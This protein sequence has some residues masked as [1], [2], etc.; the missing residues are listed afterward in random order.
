M[1]AQLPVLSLLLLLA[2]HLTSMTLFHF[3]F[4]DLEAGFRYFLDF[5]HEASLQ[6]KTFDFDFFKE[7]IINSAIVILPKMVG[8]GF[9]NSQ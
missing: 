6:K 4:P 3:Y 7:L 9:S 1:R 2:R 8:K 5:S